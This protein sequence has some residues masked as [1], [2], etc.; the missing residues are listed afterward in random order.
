MNKSLSYEETFVRDMAA[1]LNIRRMA[2]KRPVYPPAHSSRMYAAA[3]SSRLTTGFGQSN[4][5]ADSELISSLRALR[6]RARELVRDAGYVKRSKVV[7]VNN[8]IGPGIGLQAQVK[9]TS[10]ILNKRV[11]DDI[12]RTWKEWSRAVN[13]HTGGGLHFSDMERML[14]GQVFEAGEIFIRKHYRPFGESDIPYALEVIEPERILDEYQPSTLEPNAHVRMGVEVDEFYRP[15]AYWIRQ[16]HPGEVRLAPWETDY[17]ERVPANQIIHLRI[18]DRWPQT[19]GEPWLHTAMRKAYDMDGYIEAEIVR[20]RAEANKVGALKTSRPYGDEVKDSDGN[21][22]RREIASEPGSWEVLFEDEEMQFPQPTSPNSQADPFLRFMLREMAA[23]AGPSFESISRDYSQSNYSSSRLGLLEDR[24]LWRVIQMWF[25]RSFREPLHR[26]WL[27]SAIFARAIPSIPVTAF[28][29]DPLRY[30]A[31][32]YKPR[33]WS[34]VDPTTE[35]AAYKEAEKA[36]YITKSRVIALTAD[37]MDHEDM[38]EERE[39]ELKVQKEKG[40]TFDTDPVTETKMQAQNP[41]QDLAQDSG[42]DLNQDSDQSNVDDS[43]SARQSNG[44]DFDNLKQKM[45]AF[46]VGVRAGALTPQIEDEITFRS[47]A[48]LPT[49]SNAVKTAWRKDGNVRRPITLQTGDASK[50]TQNQNVSKNT[51]EP[52]EE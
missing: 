4:T 46:G 31:V 19:R 3:K 22:I 6:S 15:I 2:M 45:D 37:G 30:L 48:N 38:M 12:E 10:G 5:S 11:N 28:A 17:I 41:G 7:V 9:S 35:V 36:G 34:W 20:A 50:S 13:C 18:I 8:V 21:V 1:A 23:G 27:Q 26:D 25:I 16:R 43:D 40:L 51:D 49:M 42:K 14:M 24:D 47:E 39:H 32:R 33:G 52:K 29:V 44:V